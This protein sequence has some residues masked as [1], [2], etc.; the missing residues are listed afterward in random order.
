VPEQ[1]PAPPAARLTAGKD[2]ATLHAAAVARTS[3]TDGTGGT[4]AARTYPHYPRI[5]EGETWGSVKPGA[6][7]ARI[8]T[9]PRAGQYINLT[10]NGE[11][12]NHVFAIEQRDGKEV[13]VYSSDGDNVTVEAALDHGE[14]TAHPET[15]KNRGADQPLPGEVWEPVR[16]HRYAD[17]VGG[18]RNGLYVNTQGGPRDGMAFQI[19]TQ[20]EKVFHVYGTGEDRDVLQ[21]DGPRT[22][23]PSSLLNRASAPTGGTSSSANSA[24]EEAADKRVAA[25]AA[26]AARVAAPATSPARGVAPAA[27]EAAPNG[28]RPTETDVSTPDATAVGAASAGDR[29]AAALWDGSAMLGALID[30]AAESRDRLRREDESTESSS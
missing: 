4:A 14:A 24:A 15:V 20:G 30:P 21:V 23:V 8:L 18:P 6:H 12:R 22:G 26:S 9:G 5:P 27:A 10:R 7:H 13:H 28:S 19:V 11:L 29:A 17:I 16:G 1:A 25:P 3:A 2:F